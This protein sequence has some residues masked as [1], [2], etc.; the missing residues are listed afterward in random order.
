MKDDPY[1]LVIE[2]DTAIADFIMLAL[3][4]EGFTVKTAIDGLAGLHAVQQASP[5]LILL[6]M[7][8]PNLDGPGFAQAYRQMPV[9]QAPI[10]V[11]TASRDAAEAANIVNAEAVL[12]KPF[13]LNELIALVQQIID[14]TE[15]PV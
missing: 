5:R 13:D 11:L 6:D 15:T 7:R 8:M 1:I 2:D 4:F 9:P 12:D 14:S 3:E 10:I